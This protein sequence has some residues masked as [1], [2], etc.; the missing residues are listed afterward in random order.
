MPKTKT[1]GADAGRIPALAKAAASLML[2]SR[3]RQE[4]FDRRARRHRGQPERI[5][6]SPLADFPCAFYG[7]PPR[8]Q[9]LE[10]KPA[11]G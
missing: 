6:A 11:N 3:A 2:R 9:A 1:L 10:F 7:L 5:V 8:F 4:N